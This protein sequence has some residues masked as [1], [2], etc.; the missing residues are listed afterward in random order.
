[1]RTPVNQHAV[2]LRD[3]RRLGYLE[4][5]PRDGLLVVYL[6]GAIGVP[7]LP[8]NE[9]GAVTCDLAIHYVMVSRPGFGDS[10]PLPGR[11]LL[12]FASDVAELAD[13]LGH[14]QFAV[15]GVSAGGPYALACAHALGERV[16]A[17]S[18]V[19]SMS[20]SDG[21]SR[22]DLPPHLRLALRALRRRPALCTSAGDALL[23]LARAKPWLVERAIGAGAPRAE[24][25]NLARRASRELAAA[26]F[27]SAADRGIGAMVDD[28]GL[29]AGD[30]GFALSDVC[31]QVQLWHGV[32][33]ELVPVDAAL[34]IAAALPR[35][36]TALDPD[37]GHFF[38]HRRLRE[39][40]GDLVCAHG[41]ATRDATATQR[42]TARS[43]LRD[44][45]RAT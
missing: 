29:C 39:I 12:D 8:G 37:E 11:T 7:P 1:M 24:S 41:A 2:T 21:T 17:V 5:G 20:S 26:R 10:D 38:Y 3:G 14:H 13:Q 30:W 27:L 36:Q 16:S 32:Q 9:L 44:R 23:G 43:T 25:R 15:I 33:D 35:V 4:S 40:L 19:S 42:L 6:H 22:H 18:V 28:Y 45:H 34:H 31:C